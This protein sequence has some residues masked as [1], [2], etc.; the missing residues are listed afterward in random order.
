MKEPEERAMVVAGEPTNRAAVSIVPRTALCLALVAAL[1]GTAAAFD[2]EY[3]L[4]MA[5]VHSSNIALSEG[6]ET[7]DTVLAPRLRFAVERQGSAVTLQARGQVEHRDYLDDTFP[8]EWRGEL[9]GRLDWSVVPQRVNL[10]LEDYLSHQPVDLGVGLSPGNVQ[11]VNVF[12]GGPSFH[13]R[14]NGVTR[15]QLDLRA[16]N[17]YAEVTE[18]F[19][20]DRYSAAARLQRELGPTQQ[21][22]LNVVATEA[23]FDEPGRA[24][25]YARQDAFVSYRREQ[26]RGYL[27]FDLGRSRLDPE[28]GGR[29]HDATLARAAWAWAPT[30]RSRLNA[31]ARYQLADSAQDLIIRQS[32]LS[33]PVFR[34]LTASTLQVNSDVYRQ[35]AFHLDYRYTGDRLSLRLRP[36]YRSYRYVESTREDNEDYSGYVELGYRVRPRLT[37]TAHATALNRE[38]LDSQRKDRDRVYGLQAQYRWT[39]HLSTQVEFYRNTRSST[40]P[41]SSYGENVAGIS[42]MWLR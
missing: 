33:E 35:R 39:R 40:V 5:A 20:G 18:D 11:R 9:A 24:A 29:T 8:R 7:S 38:F 41:G 16:A 2:V 19:N 37:L 1:P 36:R 28:V 34:E 13:A 12:V 31:Y 10:V 21:A 32:D 22:S 17:S 30:A 15:A 27:E 23:E 3:E 25:D 14:F 4:G 42:L 6:A 26:A